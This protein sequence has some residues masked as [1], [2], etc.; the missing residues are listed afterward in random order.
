[1]DTFLAKV[2]TQDIWRDQCLHLDLK[3]EIIIMGDI[4]KCKLF[5]FSLLVKQGASFGWI[6]ELW[7]SL[8]PAKL[9]KEPPITASLNLMGPSLGPSLGPY[10]SRR[11]SMIIQICSDA[12]QTSPTTL[13]KI[14]IK[15]NKPKQT[16]QHQRTGAG[17]SL[18]PFQHRRAR[19]GCRWRRCTR[20]REASWPSPAPPT[21]RSGWC[22]PTTAASPSRSATTR[23]SRTGASTAWRQ[24]ASGLCRI[25]GWGLFEILWNDK[26]AFQSFGLQESSPFSF[27]GVIPSMNVPY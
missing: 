27:V 21:T 7:K 19:A 23:G 8:H 26:T 22:V 25:G 1:M 15:T 24:G 2:F 11:V 6:A 4:S 9:P 18:K 5:N 13:V 10:G 16:S 3:L 12:C 17:I 14:S 20:V